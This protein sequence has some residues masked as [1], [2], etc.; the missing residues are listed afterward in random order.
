MS[1]FHRCTLTDIG[2]SISDFLLA[3]FWLIGICFGCVCG[4]LY[5]GAFVLGSVLNGIYHRD[6]ISSLFP[7]F[8]FLTSFALSSC[9]LV[10]LILP[11]AFGKGFIDTFIL[12]LFLSSPNCLG[13]PS[14]SF[15]FFQQFLLLPALFCFWC[16]LLRGDHDISNT[17]WWI[18]LYCICVFLVYVSVSVHM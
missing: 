12:C 16:C 14:V 17:L 9:G 3:F 11:I 2:F 18:V 15:P 4:W 1:I 5:D 6:L 13:W 7:Y 10:N 8:L